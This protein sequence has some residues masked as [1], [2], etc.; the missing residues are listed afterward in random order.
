ME[1][2]S[3]VEG[4]EKRG[5]DV[6][7]EFGMRSGNMVSA[8]LPSQ[9]ITLYLF[10]FPRPSVITNTIFGLVK[11]KSHKMLLLKVKHIHFFLLFPLHTKK[12][13]RKFIVPQAYPSKVDLAP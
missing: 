5:K 9:V 10:A 1:F 4:S 12:F 13:E 11:L 8:Y 2:L 3:K 7:M 6:V